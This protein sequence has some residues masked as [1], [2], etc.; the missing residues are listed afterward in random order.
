MEKYNLKFIK[1]IITPSDLCVRVILGPVF[2][3][4]NFSG[5]GPSFDYITA[6]KVDTS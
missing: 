3:R 2:S 1:E 6:N 5:A 4:L